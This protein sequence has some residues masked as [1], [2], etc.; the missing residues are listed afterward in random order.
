MFQL[1]SFQELAI[2]IPVFLLAL[3]IHEVRTAGRRTG[4]GIGRRGSRGA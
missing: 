3:T 4:W 1:P 2:R